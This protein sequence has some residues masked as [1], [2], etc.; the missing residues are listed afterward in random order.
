M[1]V[2]NGPPHS[3]NVAHDGQEA[4]LID[5]IGGMRADSSALLRE[6]VDTRSAH[7]AG[8]PWPASWLRWERPDRPHEPV[9]IT[10]HRGASNRHLTEAA[11]LLC[12]HPAAFAGVVTHEVTPE[13]AAEVFT[14]LARGGAR[15]HEG[16]RI[17]KLAIR[18]HYVK[19]A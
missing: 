5:V 11:H 18:F 4:T 2:T 6:A 8:S 3:N 16:R 14:S 13:V 9:L 1:D 10:G 17:Q 15:E 7:V 19:E 12:R